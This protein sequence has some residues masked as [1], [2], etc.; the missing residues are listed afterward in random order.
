MTPRD[1]EGRPAASAAGRACFLMRVR[2]DRLEPYLEA[3]QHVWAEMQEALRRAGWRDYALFVDRATGLVVG[4]LRSG[5]FA[6][7][8]ARMADE[9]VNT[10]WQAAMGD[11]FAP[12]DERT[13]PGD[14]VE[15]EEYFHLD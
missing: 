12:V 3:H 1:T 15:L 5:D 7:A 11:W 4:T 14:I 8:Q 13:A 9:D 10:R 2:L 6:A